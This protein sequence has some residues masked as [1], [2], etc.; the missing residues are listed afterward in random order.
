MRLGLAIGAAVLGLACSDAIAPASDAGNDR[1]GVVTPDGSALPTDA[2]PRLLSHQDVMI[3]SIQLGILYVGDLDAGAAPSQDVDL[4]WVVG[5]P[6]WLLL[7][8]YGVGNGAVAASARLPT[9][10]FFQSGDLDPN[11][12]VEM[13]VLQARLLAALH[14]DS[15]AGTTSTV[16][17]PGANAIVVYLPDGINVALGHK[18]SYTY[19]TCIDSDGYHAYDGIEPYA[20]LPPCQVGRTLYA[21]AHELAEMATDPQPY[22]GWASDV[23]VPVNGGEVADLCAEQTFTY[24]LWLTRLW[25]N[26]AGG[27][28][29]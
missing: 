27:C 29:P 12:L 24:G 8:E 28:V 4:N 15:D 17:L 19:Q 25:S 26:Q 7:D 11:G 2:A 14:G 9:A 18:G 10:S 20:V 5:S 22:I 1:T 21:A 3:P 6:Y 13:V 16:T 23:D